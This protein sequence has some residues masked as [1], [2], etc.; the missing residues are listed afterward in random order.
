MHL[1]KYLEQCLAQRKRLINSIPRVV[2]PQ[3]YIHTVPQVTSLKTYHELKFYS[4]LRADRGSPLGCGPGS[5]AGLG[6]GAGTTQGKGHTGHSQLV[7][8]RN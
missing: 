7:L 6:L 1:V 3:A 4:R 5:L 2:C 8:V